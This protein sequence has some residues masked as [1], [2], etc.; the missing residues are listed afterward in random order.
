MRAF[1]SDVP[2]FGM[3]SEP[4]WREHLP[5][6]AEMD[7]PMPVELLRDERGIHGIGVS[8]LFDHEAIAW[9][10]GVEPDLYR[11]PAPA[12]RPNLAA[13]PFDGLRIARSLFHVGQCRRRPTKDQRGA[14]PW[15][16]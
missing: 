15:S 5:A 8:D 2:L 12:K 14:P 4:P 11:S 16:F 6:A 1:D 3:E 9:S 7:V 13:R 10:C